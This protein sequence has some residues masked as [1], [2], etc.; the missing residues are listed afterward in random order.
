MYNV[1]D[2]IIAVSS[3]ATPSIKKIIRISG[4]RTF[5]ILKSFFDKDFEKRKKIATLSANID[6]LE[7]ECWVYLFCSPNSYTGEDIAEIHICGCD[8]IIELI[9]SKLL[10]LECRAA[11]AGEFTYRAYVNGKMDLSVAEA[12]ALMIESSN[13]YQLM[14]AQK[15]FGGSIEKKV[16]KIRQDIL[17]LLSMIEAGLDFGAEDIEIISNQKAIESAQKLIGELK[18]LISGSITFEQISQAPSVVIAGAANAGKSSL[19]NALIGEQRSIVSDQSGTTRDV[20]EHWLRLNKCDCVLFDCAGIVTTPDGILQNLANE[21]AMKAVKDA[22]ILIFCAD[23]TKENY[24]D[25]VQILKQI[26]KKPN[27]FIASKSDLLSDEQAADAKTKLKNI[28]DHDFLVLSVHQNKSIENLKK[29]IEQ[30]IIKQTSTTSEAGEKTALTERHRQAV[31]EAMK[32]INSAAIEF[33]NKNEE[34]SAFLLRAALENLSKI[35]AEHIDES[36]LDTI[37][38]RFCIGK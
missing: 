7:I 22:I 27:I 25:D 8:K 38:S 9:F 4:D 2:T 29:L 37:F 13:Q 20:L 18:E 34:I 15:L 5:E 30:N 21:A 1:N 14:A 32:N 19:V 28:F 23:I 31:N 35:E 26:K 11:L 33:E 12:V 17:E 24:L 36:I 16:G 10:S 6:G 3:G